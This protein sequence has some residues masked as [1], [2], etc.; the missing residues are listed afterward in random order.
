MESL[1]EL[2]TQRA[3]GPTPSFNV[4]DLLRVLEL[5][6][7]TGSVGRGKLAEDLEIGAGVIRT[8]INRLREAGLISIS[9]LGCSLTPKGLELWNEFQLVLPQKVRLTESDLAL[10]PHSVAILVKSRSDR[11]RNGLEQRD[12][13]V[14]AGSKGAV[15][16]VF[17]KNRLAAPMVSE[18]VAKDYPIAFSQLTRVMKLQENDVVVVA[19]AESLKRAEYGALA[20]AWTLI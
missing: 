15:T 16:L 5:I 7:R 6:A 3:P 4:F 18:D 20:A 11:V 8:L 13:A 17:T 9:K 1:S 12:A 19:C 14:A 2:L 10:A